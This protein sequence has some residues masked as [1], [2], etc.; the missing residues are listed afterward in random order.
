VRASEIAEEASEA[1]LVRRGLD[2]RH[3][4]FGDQVRIGLLDDDLSVRD[5]SLEQGAAVGIRLPR[6]F[7]EAVEG[8]GRLP[9]RVLKALPSRVDVC[10]QHEC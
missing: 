1:D 5:D 9:E 8:V 7:V 10:H 4:A 6:L 3:G 2:R